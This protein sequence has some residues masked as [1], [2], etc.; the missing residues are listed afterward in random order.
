MFFSAFQSECLLRDFLIIAISVLIS[1][2]DLSRSRSFDHFLPFF[3]SLLF[4]FS[5]HYYVSYTYSSTDFLLITNDFSVRDVSTFESDIQIY[6]DIIFYQKSIDVRFRYVFESIVTFR[7]DVLN[8]DL[9]AFLFFV[10]G[11]P[12][13]SI[14]DGYVCLSF[15]CFFSFFFVFW[16]KINDTIL[17]NICNQ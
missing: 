12:L 16:S 11:I 2:L 6:T 3:S 10:Y 4:V 17:I 15:Q 5:R 1:S 8:V 14:I 9:S 13:F 7:L